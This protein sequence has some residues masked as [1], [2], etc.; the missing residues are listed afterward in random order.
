MFYP[1]IEPS[2][3]ESTVQSL[4]EVTK[5]Y[6]PF[7]VTLSEFD[8]FGGKKSGVCWVQP[9]TSENQIV[10]LYR[11]LAMVL[12]R[13]MNVDSNFIPHLT[14]GHFANI[15]Q[16]RE[17]ADYAR[18]VWVTTSFTVSEIYIIQRTNDN[19][20]YSITWRIPLGP[21]DVGSVSLSGPIYEGDSGCRFIHMPIVEEDWIR[22]MKMKLTK[23]KRNTKESDSKAIEE[24][25]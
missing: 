12:S 22:D 2:Q 20:Q 13:W 6:A 18:S 21:N 1:F 7:E 23:S 15:Q 19:D 25:T 16:A 10:T 14:V 3:F 11:K 9:Q 8:T 5:E 24:N 17:A 4:Y